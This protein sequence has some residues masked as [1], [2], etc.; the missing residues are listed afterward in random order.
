ML[1]VLLHKLCG[2]AAAN[3]DS[4]HDVCVRVALQKTKP[5]RSFHLKVVTGTPLPRDLPPGSTLLNF[6]TKPV[7][8]FFSVVTIGASLSMCHVPGRTAAADADAIPEGQAEF[9]LGIHGEKGLKRMQG[10]V[11]A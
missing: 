3:G 11:V 4:I 9:G 5:E 10:G 6:N 8:I 7:I 1:Q 2:A